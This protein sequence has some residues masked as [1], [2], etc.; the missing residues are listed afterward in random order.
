[1]RQHE[2]IDCA[3]RQ[4]VSGGR[5]HQPKCA[6]HA[7][8]ILGAISRRAFAVDPLVVLGTRRLA[9]V[10]EGGFDC[11]Y[12]LVHLDTVCFQATRKGNRSPATPTSNP[13]LTPDA[14]IL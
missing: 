11:F 10:K 7:G 2:P 4:Q 1:M 14:V 5:I 3:K 6:S 12:V 13:T 9:E 8:G